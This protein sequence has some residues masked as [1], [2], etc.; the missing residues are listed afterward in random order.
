MKQK[1]RLEKIESVTSM[2]MLFWRFILEIPRNLK[3]FS[4]LIN[5]PKSDDKQLKSENHQSLYL[6]VFHIHELYVTLS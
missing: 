4:I 3:A 1:P 6:L 5:A 2:K